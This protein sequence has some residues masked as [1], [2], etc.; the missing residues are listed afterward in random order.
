MERFD[1]S[2]FLFFVISIAGA[3]GLSFAF[4]LYSGAKKTVAY[5]AVHTLKNSFEEVFAETSTLSKI[6]PKHFLHT[7][8]YDGAGVTINNFSGG[9]EELIFLSGFF[10]KSNELRLIRRDGTI[11]ARWP[12]RFSE[13]FPNPSHCRKKPDT[14]WNVGIHGALALPDGSVVFNFEWAGLVKLDRCGKIVWTLA[15]ESHHSVERSEGGGFWVPGNRFFSKESDSPFPPFKTPISENTIMK[16]SEDG[17][18]LTEISVIKLFYDNGLEALLTSTGH[19]FGPRVVAVGK[20]F[21]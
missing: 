6:H 18:V 4:G 19:K 1:I 3:L 14:D 12:V 2:K 11:I 13:I 17:E 5:R 20:L 21:I 16:V 15:R 9:E 7:A 10:N 8:R